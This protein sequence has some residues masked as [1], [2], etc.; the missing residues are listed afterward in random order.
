MKQYTINFIIV[1]SL[2]IAAIF[3]AFCI[4]AS[5]ESGVRHGTTHGM[6]KAYEGYVISYDPPV[7]NVNNYVVDLRSR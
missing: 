7:C 2:I 4:S 5:Y 6:C 1:L 3:F